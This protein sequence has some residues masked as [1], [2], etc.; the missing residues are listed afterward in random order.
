MAERPRPGFSRA[1][2]Q[3][4]DATLRDHE[5]HQIGYRLQA[6]GRRNGPDWL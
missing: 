5:R 2:I 3:R 6:I 1:L 4:D